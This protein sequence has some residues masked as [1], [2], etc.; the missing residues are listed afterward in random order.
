MLPML[1]LPL[2]VLVGVFA[3]AIGSIVWVVIAGRQRQEVLR[4]ASGVGEQ[5]VSAIRAEQASPLQG[6]VDWLA[7]RVPAQLG[8]GTV[9]ASRLVHAG[10]DSAAAGPIYSLL[11]VVSLV[12][13]TGLALLLAPIGDPILY[14]AVVLLTIHWVEVLGSFFPASGPRLGLGSVILMTDVI[15]L[16]LYVSSCHS[17]RHIVGGRID[18]FS[19]SR[20][21]RT[22]HS[23]WKRLTGLNERH[24]VYAW[25]SLISVVVADLYI[26][27]LA[28]G[29]LTDPAIRF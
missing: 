9:S 19:C 18:C 14:G 23:A 8:I 2:I 28:M 21:T 4:R 25:A 24:M 16:S 26:H 12:L 15:L 13:C 6:F 20:V 5:R 17:L 22:R 11:R 7:A 3:L 27:M 10:F 29:V 1:S